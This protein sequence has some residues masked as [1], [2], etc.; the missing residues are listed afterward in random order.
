M[1][2]FDFNSN[3]KPVID[4]F[5]EKVKADKS[6][7]VLIT[8]H[9]DNTGDAAKNLN[10]YGVK[11]AEALKNYMV[12]QGVSADQITC[13]SKGQTQPVAPNTTKENRA[14]NR[15]AHIRVL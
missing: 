12:S 2:K 11:R 9:T 13:E 14:L 6:I 1:T 5:C 4:K 3:E 10:Y 7:K 8:G 15:R